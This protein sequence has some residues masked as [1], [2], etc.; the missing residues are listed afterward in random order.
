MRQ[1]RQQL[2]TFIESARQQHQLHMPPPRL[3]ASLL[4]QAMQLLPLPDSNQ[5]KK[6]TGITAQTLHQHSLHRHLILI[7][8]PDQAFY[9]DALKGYLIQQDIHPIAQQTMVLSMQCRENVCDI[10]L[11][12]PQ[13]QDPSNFMFI[14]LH[15]ST[16]LIQDCQPLVQDM[17]AVLHAV[18]LSIQDFPNMTKQLAHIADS[19]HS[20]ASEH[21]NLLHWMND[22]RYLLFGMQTTTIKTSDAHR[23]Q[24][25]GLMRQKRILNK[26][27]P[28]L[29]A[30]LQ[31]AEETCDEGMNWLHIHAIQHHIYST[32]R[33]E[34]LRILWKNKQGIMMETTVIGHFSRSA[35]HANASQTPGIVPTR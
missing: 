31:D 30:Q 15:L 5:G 18:E 27:I 1:I 35:R 16:T 21:A 32:T 24:R 14:A 7:R 29:D 2:L 22:G 17:Q 33:V 28:H 10:E 6:T 26:I 34:L 19:I 20:S 8:C 4:H 23:D 13:S 25:W 11:R 9:L 3:Q 12:Q